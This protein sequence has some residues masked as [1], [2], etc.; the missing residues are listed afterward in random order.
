MKSFKNFLIEDI[1]DTTWL[2]QGLSTEPWKPTFK[3][4]QDYMQTKLPAGPE[5]TENFPPNHPLG[6]NYAQ[7]SDIHFGPD[8][9]H[10][11]RTLKAYVSGI[12]WNKKLRES[13][14]P[15]H[16]TEEALQASLKH[17]SL[18][19]PALQDEFATNIKNMDEIIERKGI[20][21]PHPLTV[22]RSARME[23]ARSGVEHGFISTTLSGKVAASWRIDPNSGQRYGWMNP[24][25]R[26]TTGHAILQLTIPAGTKFLPLHHGHNVPISV[27]Q[28]ILLGRGHEIELGPESKD[29]LRV[30]VKPQMGSSQTM[31]T[32]PVFKGIIKPRRTK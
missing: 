13:S 22:F 6:R 1:G 26:S 19:S 8:E 14:R 30:A 4:L 16:S 3:W 5:G 17:K 11:E 10:L 21:L 23:S 27:E 20:T 31:H 7:I 12:D 24:S 28:E 29:P 9:A 32:V 18:S 2:N 25:G 15:E